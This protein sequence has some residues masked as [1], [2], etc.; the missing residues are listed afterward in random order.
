VVGDVGEKEGVA[1][2]EVRDRASG[3]VWEVNNQ[4]FLT[5]FQEKRMAVRPDHILQFAHHL[6][7]HYQ[8]EKQLQECPSVSAEVY[9]TLN[10]RVSQLLI[11]P[12][13]DLTTKSRTLR[14]TDWILP[15]EE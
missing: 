4:A 13:V 2:F 15:L 1:R 8:Q 9:V 3:R 12:T 7:A 5:P 11:D 14:Q 6:A 10:G